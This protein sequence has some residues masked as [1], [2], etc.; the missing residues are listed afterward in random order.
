M[1][2]EQILALEQHRFKA[3]CAADAGALNELLH[4]DLKYTHS[5]G[6]WDSAGKRFSMAA[7]SGGRPVLVIVDVSQPNDRKEIPLDDLSA[8]LG[9]S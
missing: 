3:M 8:A 9:G 4:R 6:A 7:L 2:K 1:T 5:S